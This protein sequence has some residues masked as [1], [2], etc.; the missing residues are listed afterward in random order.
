MEVQAA[1]PTQQK[2][3]GTEHIIRKEDRQ[4]SNGPPSAG[5]SYLH[6]WRLHVTTLGIVL[7]LFI[8]NLEVT[9]VSTSLVDITND[10]EGFD[11]TSWIVTGYLITFTA[12][13]IT[14]AKLSD[15]FGRKQTI[16][17]SVFIFV[18]FSAGCG[19]S[20]TLDQLRGIGAAGTYSMAALITYEMVLKSKL[21]VYGGINSVAVA[22]ATLMG[23]VFG[24]LINNNGSWSLP[25]GALVTF[26]L[27]LGMPSSFPD[28]AGTSPNEKKKFPFV[29]RVSLAKLEVLGAGLLLSGSLLLATAL[30]EASN[31]FSWSSGGT[32][33]LLV[34]SGLSW[35]CFFLWEWYITGR[36]GKQEPVFPWRFVHDRSFMGMLITT[37]LVG[38]PFN[39]VIMILPQRFQTTSGASPLA[40]GIRLLPYTFGAALGAVF[41]NVIGS[42][43]RIAVIYILFLGA[44]LQLL[45]LVLLSTLPATRDLP[46]KAYG[47]ETLAGVGVGVTF[48]ILVLA[49][50]YVASPRDLGESCH[51]E[52]I[53]ALM[54]NVYF[55][56]PYFL[57]VATGAIIQFRLLGGLIGLSFASNVMNGYLKT[58]LTEILS[59][60]ALAALLKTTKVLATFAPDVREKVIEVFAQSYD[61]QYTLMIAFAAAQFPAAAMLW[62]KKEQ[63]KAG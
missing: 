54:D 42:K 48:G 62:K 47:F 3:C 16:I 56:Q 28:P 43:R 38:V 24:G 34:V 21:P 7:S 39:A 50:P 18:G 4:S 45:G 33:S 44:L 14:W 57:T 11:R 37:F 27:F 2:S 13:M 6:G 51:N 63:I 23:P 10:L 5:P 26:T 59:S 25:V 20:R 40:A 35:I 29:S 15:I 49:T 41:A 17:T 8:V 9:I 60:D 61:L 12:F 53:L 58:H 22:L 52:R 31:R 46:G 55:H 30:L 36:D 1:D 32:I 19:G